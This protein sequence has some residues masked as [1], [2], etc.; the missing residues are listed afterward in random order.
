MI[1]NTEAKLPPEDLT[2]IREHGVPLD[3]SPIYVHF[4]EGGAITFTDRGKGLYRLS[5][6][7]GGMSAQHAERIVDIEGLRKLSLKIKRVRL[8][9]AERQAETVRTGG[10]LALRS[11]PIVEAV[12][13]GT[14]DDF[15]AAVDLCL[16]CNAAG[17]NVIPMSFRANR[18]Q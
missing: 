8:M 14:L 15:H 12:V 10:R 2:I 9:C 7:L 16:A 18:T 6:L 1:F 17:E 5:C 13:R 4:E 3:P 11:R